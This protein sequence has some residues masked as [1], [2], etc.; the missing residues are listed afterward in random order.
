VVADYLEEDMNWIN[1]MKDSPMAWREWSGIQEQ[2]DD[3]I[4]VVVVD[5]KILDVKETDR[6]TY[7]INAQITDSHEKFILRN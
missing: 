2:S 7:E 1:E 3:Y 6:F 5:G 4:P